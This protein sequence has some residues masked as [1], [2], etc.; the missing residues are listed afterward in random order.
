[1]TEEKKT[2][3]YKAFN[4][5]F[6]CRNFQFEVGKTYEQ[7]GKISVC[8][9]GFHA[10]ENPFDVLNYYELT[11]S[12]FAEVELSGDTDTHEDD[13]KIAASKVTI[14]AELKLPEF[15]NMRGE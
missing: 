14:K 10:C 4:K 11:E 15:I 5:D 12:K 13:S 8:N 2:I 6:T 9:K 3:A 1:M 7:E